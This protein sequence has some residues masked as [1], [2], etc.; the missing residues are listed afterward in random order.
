MNAMKAV[1]VKQ[2]WAEG[3]TTVQLSQ[4]AAWHG[5]LTISGGTMSEHTPDE[6]SGLSLANGL[7][8]R[9]IQLHPVFAHVPPPGTDPRRVYLASLAPGSRRAMAGALDT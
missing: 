7:M 1:D 5:S 3:H 6:L 4:S 9:A 2:R 8:D